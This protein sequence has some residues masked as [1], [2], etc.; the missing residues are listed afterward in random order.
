MRQGNSPATDEKKVGEHFADG[1][2][3]EVHYHRCLDLPGHTIIQYIFQIKNRPPAKCFKNIQR[4][5]FN[6][7]ACELTRFARTPEN[8]QNI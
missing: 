6:I 8:F 5:Y 4:S 7:Y 1:N 2:L 3:A